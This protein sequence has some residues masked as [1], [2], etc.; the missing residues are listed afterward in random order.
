LLLI[1]FPTTVGGGKIF[2]VL[3]CSFVFVRA[4]RMIEPKNIFSPAPLKS[5]INCHNCDR[6]FNLIVHI[7]TVMEVWRGETLHSR[8]FFALT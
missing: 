2:C 3:L 1:W 8:Y 4:A 6:N 5:R 7:S